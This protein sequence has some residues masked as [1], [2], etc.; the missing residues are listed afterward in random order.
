VN[1]LP[2]PAAALSTVCSA[3]SPTRLQPAAYSKPHLVYVPSSQGLTLVHFAAQSEQSLKQT[4]T[5]H[6]H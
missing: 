2:P 5:L 4:H 6:T 3:S 1:T